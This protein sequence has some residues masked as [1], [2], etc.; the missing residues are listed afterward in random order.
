MF[1]FR[2]DCFRFTCMLP[3]IQTSTQHSVECSEL[4]VKRERE[5][6]GELEKREHLD[7]IFVFN[8]NFIHKRQ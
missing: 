7:N 4:N 1:L 5:S 8:E 2:L 6:V 3:K